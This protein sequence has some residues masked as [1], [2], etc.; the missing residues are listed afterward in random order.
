MMCH[1]FQFSASSCNQL[2][3]SIKHA[4]CIFKRCVCITVMEVVCKQIQHA[5]GKGKKIFTAIFLTHKTAS[6]TCVTFHSM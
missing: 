5:V 2:R 4:I 6:A 1:V 3:L